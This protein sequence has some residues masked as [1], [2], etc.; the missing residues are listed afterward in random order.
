MRKLNKKDFI[1][2]SI[3]AYKTCVCSSCLRSCSCSCTPIREYNSNH[4]AVGD[5][6]NKHNADSVYVHDFDFYE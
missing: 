6:R 2:N 3:E 5:S 1:N 4:N